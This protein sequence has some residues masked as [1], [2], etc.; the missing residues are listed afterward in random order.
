MPFDF[1]YSSSS[2]PASPSSFFSAALAFFLLTRP[3]RPPP[4]GEFSAKSICFWESRR[5]TKD[6]T[7]TI[8]FPTL[9]K[10][11]QD[12]FCTHE[13]STRVVPNV[14][15]PDQNSSMMDTLGQTELVYA[16]L[17]SPLQK[18]LHFECEHVIELH[19]GFIKHTHTDETTNQGVSFEKTF[20]VL[21]LHSEK[22]T[23]LL[24]LD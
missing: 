3:G 23:V 21:F 7:L 4:N 12:Q 15:L 24:I 11:P 18:I 8:C 16:S 9:K 14:P 2:S 13:S 10:R 17:Q 6:G 1:A 22:L 19:A 5:T 20:W